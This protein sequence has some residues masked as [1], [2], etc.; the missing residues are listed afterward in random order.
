[1]TR[2]RRFVGDQVVQTEI[3]RALH[4]VDLE[5]VVLDSHEKLFSFDVGGSEV[6]IIVLLTRFF[7][8]RGTLNIRIERFAVG[9]ELLVPE[10]L[11]FGEALFVGRFF[12]V[13]DQHLLKIR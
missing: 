6:G 3:D 5:L 7:Q 11:C 2:R 12:Q 10:A 1:M 13:G 9:V 8:H 4:A